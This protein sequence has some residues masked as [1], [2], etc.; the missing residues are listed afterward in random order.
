MADK[1]LG[2]QQL[3]NALRTCRILARGGLG[4]AMQ[5]VQLA[6]SSLKL[7]AM[8]YSPPPT[9][10]LSCMIPLYLEMAALHG[11]AHAEAVVCTSV[12][13]C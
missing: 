13:V 12:P 8:A 4:D 2:L 3:D 10:L 11:V 5:A 6:L 9:A 7:E 1:S